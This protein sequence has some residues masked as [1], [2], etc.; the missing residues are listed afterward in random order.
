MGILTQESWKEPQLPRTQEQLLRVLA[1]RLSWYLQPPAANGLSLQDFCQYV[2]QRVR[3]VMGL[4]KEF[5]PNIGTELS[6]RRPLIRH[7]VYS[8]L[9][10]SKFAFTDGINEEEIARLLK[11]DLEWSQTRGFVVVEHPHHPLYTAS[12][13]RATTLN[14]YDIRALDLHTKADTNLMKWLLE[15][16]FGALVSGMPELTTY[17]RNVKIVHHA[18]DL[19]LKLRRL[20]WDAVDPPPR[21]LLLTDD[22][23]QQVLDALTEYWVEI[24]DSDNMREQAIDVAKRNGVEGLFEWKRNEEGPL[25]SILEKLQ[26]SRIK[27]PTEEIEWNPMLQQLIFQLVLEGKYEEGANLAGAW[28]RKLMEFQIPPCDRPTTSLATLAGKV[29]NVES[30]VAEVLDRL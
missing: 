22:Q 8:I 25:K 18:V 5:N 21:E 16:D 1:P 13:T 29:S 20:V 6:L 7:F 19:R 10:H 2:H 27:S 17:S 23:R 3:D 26:P 28:G 12:Q 24:P 15:R 14:G 4:G 30:T 9:L 11:R